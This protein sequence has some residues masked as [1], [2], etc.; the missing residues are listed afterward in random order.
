[1][2]KIKLAKNIGI[3][4]FSVFISR[5][6]GLVRDQVMAYYFGTTHLNDAFNVAYNLPNLI[7]RLFGEGALSAV[8]VPMYKEI[9]KNRNKNEQI[10]FAVN[11]LSILT[12]FLSL[13]TFLGIILSP[14]IIRILYPGLSRETLEISIKLSIIMF[15]YLFFIGLSS[16]FIAILNSHDYFFMTG[17]SSA[18][19]NIGM[20]FTVV[21]PS[22][23]F[24]LDGRDLVFWAGWGVFLGGF[25]QSIINFPFLKHIGYRF[26]IFL[27]FTSDNILILWRRFFP[28]MIGIGIREINLVFDALMASFLPIGSITALSIGNRIM[29]MPLGIFAISTGTVLL[30]KYSDHISD[31]DWK[32][33]SE[34][35]QFTTI[36][37]ALI[38]F[39]IMA[40]FCIMGKDI[41]FILFQRGVFDNRAT[42]LTEQALFYYGLG[43]FFFAVNQTVTPLYYALK[44]TKTPVKVAG[45]M[46]GLNIL[47]NFVLMQFMQ[48]RGLA[49]STSITACV[50]Y[51][52]L[53][54]VLKKKNPLLDFH[55]IVNQVGRIVLITFGLSLI[56]YLIY[57][58]LPFDN[59]LFIV[60]KNFALCVFFYTLFIFFTNLFRIKYIAI[61]YKVLWSRLMKK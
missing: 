11:V 39:P 22:Y 60:I 4:S 53:V 38:M 2:S 41:I 19:L 29:Q 57:K 43:L 52:V 10:H 20:I 42:I 33:L 61:T 34:S 31:N 49:L 17:L 45:F 32:K 59:I 51:I 26:R 44:D 1:M 3:M 47:L 12:L 8:F 35:L 28:A 54:R 13:L 18:M 48:H 7:R 5:I 40:L 36:S 58:S 21:F 27:S 50:N 23:I 46:V 6:L 55:G 24:N 37:L 25:F 30:P 56:V 16:T 9:G 15:P 14:Y